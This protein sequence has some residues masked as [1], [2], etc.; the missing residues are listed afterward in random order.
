MVILPAFDFTPQISFHFL[1]LSA[2]A[3]PLG[4]R[5][6]QQATILRLFLCSWCRISCFVRYRPDRRW[7]F[8]PQF[9]ALFI[10]STCA[11]S[12]SASRSK[13][14]RLEGGGPTAISI[15]PGGAYRFWQNRAQCSVLAVVQILVRSSQIWK[16]N[17]LT[18]FLPS[19]GLICG[20]GPRAWI[21]TCE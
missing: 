11:W 8:Y 17:P 6:R 4:P 14:A 10:D 12:G 15:H 9:Q 16:I 18:V 5:D 13:S 1:C 19:F 20:N 21:V 3:F 7:L 2:C